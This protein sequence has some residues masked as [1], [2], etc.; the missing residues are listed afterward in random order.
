[1]VCILKERR[2][3]IMSSYATTTGSGPFKAV[4]R[5]GEILY[6]SKTSWTNEEN[7]LK[8]A[9]QIFAIICEDEKHTLE[10]YK[11]VSVDK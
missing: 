9:E 8:Y 7:T 4:I 11:F 6:E 1:M 10:K 2:D 3:Y 5:S